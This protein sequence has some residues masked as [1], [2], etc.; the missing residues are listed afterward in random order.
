MPLL[1]S[2]FP[3]STID[4]CFVDKDIQAQFKKQLVRI[5]Q[6]IQLHEF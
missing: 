1:L 4:I 5:A 3:I 2:L 6:V